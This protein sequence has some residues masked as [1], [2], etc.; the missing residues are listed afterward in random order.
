MPSSAQWEA[1]K[2]SF[3]SRRH[4][5][6]PPGRQSEIL[7]VPA[8]REH[9]LQTLNFNQKEA[10]KLFSKHCLSV[11]HAVMMQILFADIFQ[12][13]LAANFISRVVVFFPSQARK[14]ITESLIRISRRVLFAFLGN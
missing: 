7:H 4:V 11:C 2:F 13:G 1:Q 3:V 8:A 6:L 12:A 5:G 10:E 14:E 9:V